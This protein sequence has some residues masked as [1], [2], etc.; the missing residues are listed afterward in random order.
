MNEGRINQMTYG[1]LSVG[2]I[3]LVCFALYKI[4]QLAIRVAKKGFDSVG[5]RFTRLQRSEAREIIPAYVFPT[6]S[7]SQ[8]DFTRIANKTAY[9]HPR[10][11]DVEVMDNTVTIQIASQSGLSHSRAILTFMLSGSSIGNYVIKSDNDD[12]TI[13]NRIADKIRVEIRKNVGFLESSADV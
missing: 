11:E 12:S 7:I 5:S 13:P 4:I 9:R 8:S 6:F 1:L 3:F 2:F 10:I